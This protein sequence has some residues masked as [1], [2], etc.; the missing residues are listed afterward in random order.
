M[1]ENSR[2]AHPMM[3]FLP[4]SAFPAG[5]HAYDDAEEN[6]KYEQLLHE[7]LL[8]WCNDF[9]LLNPARFF[10]VA[11]RLEPGITSFFS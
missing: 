2:I 4:A 1:S 6:E 9:D 11:P 5:P 7:N 10:R 8:N 3:I